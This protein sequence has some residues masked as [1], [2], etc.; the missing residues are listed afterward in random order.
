VS[1]RRLALPGFRSVLWGL[2]GAASVLGV[3]RAEPLFFD[4]AKAEL[5]YDQRTSEPIVSFRFT[6]DSARN[7]AEFT[8]QNVGRAT[9]LRVDGKTLAR[10]V[11][12][13]PILG[14][15][16]QISGHFSEP[17]ARDLVAR[18]SAG[19]KIEIEAVAN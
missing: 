7:F 10:P 4:V 11:I 16:G 5:A 12:R 1:P 3:A 14:G 15:A 13:E 6:A 2:L 8:A 19:T 17:E 18:L 9:E